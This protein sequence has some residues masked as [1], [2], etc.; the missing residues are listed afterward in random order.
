MSNSNE[1]DSSAILSKALEIK[2]ED[3]NLNESFNQEIK[4]TISYG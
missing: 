1:K 3:Y 4:T 2:K